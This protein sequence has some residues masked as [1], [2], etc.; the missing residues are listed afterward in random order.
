MKTIKYRRTSEI[1]LT[2]E[3]RLIREIRVK[4]GISIREAGR[5][6]GCSETLIRHIETGRVDFPKEEKLKRIL[7]I[8]GTSYRQFM[9][10][11][12]TKIE[13][14]SIVQIREMLMTLNDEELMVVLRI[15]RGIKGVYET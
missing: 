11:A 7:S 12:M 13:A 15:L 1:R 5:R 3:A 14:S 6:L 10:R 9:K 8:Y 2:N 4:L